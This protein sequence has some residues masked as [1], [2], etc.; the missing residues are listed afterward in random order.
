MCPGA[1]AYLGTRTLKGDEDS[2]KRR[3]RSLHVETESKAVDWLVFRE[4]VMFTQNQKGLFI[5]RQGPEIRNVQHYFIFSKQTIHRE[6]SVG[7]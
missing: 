5:V 3:E 6:K 1:S 4:S 7:C 2:P